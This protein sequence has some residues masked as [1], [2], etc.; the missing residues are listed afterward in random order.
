[1]PAPTPRLAALTARLT[2]WWMHPHFLRAG[3]WRS[4]RAEGTEHARAL[5]GDDS[6]PGARASLTHAIT[7]ARRPDAVWPWLVQMGA[8][9]RA[10]WYSYDFLDNGRHASA[11]RLIPELQRTSAGTILPALPGMT[12]GF[13][14]LALEPAR[15]L[16]LGWIGPDGAPAATW[17]FF[18][19][20]R[21]NST[22]LISRARGGP[23]YSFHG[24]PP[25]LSGALIRFVHFVMQRKQLLGIARR[26]E[27]QDSTAVS[28]GDLRLS[29]RRT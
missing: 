2:D 9:P 20:D 1:M 5:P 10:G 26:V 19:E 16:V 22:R 18:L 11:T 6:I 12:D 8:N 13:T 14:V 4:V 27:A 25:A 21:G 28:A 23:G 29:G 7:I 24:L 3:A 15:S 17:S